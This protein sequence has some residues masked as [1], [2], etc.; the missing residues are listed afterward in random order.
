MNRQNRKGPVSG[1]LLI[2]GDAPQ[3]AVPMLAVPIVAVP[4]VMPPRAEAK[5]YRRTVV[6]I[7]VA[8]LT[9][10]VVAATIVR[11]R[12]ADANAYPA[13]AGVKANLR[14]CR[15]GGEDGRCCNKTK[16]DL[17]HDDSPLGTWLGKRLRRSVVPGTASCW[18]RVPRKNY[19]TNFAELWNKKFL[20]KAF[21]NKF[22]RI[23][24]AGVSFIQRPRASLRALPHARASCRSATIG[25]DRDRDRSPAS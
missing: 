22:W 20:N 14:H 16:R 8:T 11:S 3:L 10:I 7:V 15:R 12:H 25:S 18:S 1:A 17:F 24:R 4:I 9:R 19:R 5:G 13:G 23:C 2:V 21:L 6:V